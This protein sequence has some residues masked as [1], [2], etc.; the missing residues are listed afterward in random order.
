[1]SVVYLP[2]AGFMR[3][4]IMDTWNGMLVEEKGRRRRKFQ[5]GEKKSNIKIKNKNKTT[6]FGMQ[7]PGGA[8]PYQGNVPQG[9]LEVIER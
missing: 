6:A 9:D 8:S 1:M 5:A 2:R 3:S 7:L 4:G